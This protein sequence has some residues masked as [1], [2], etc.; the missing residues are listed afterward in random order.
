MGYASAVSIKV[1]PA[2]KAAWIVVIERRRSGRPTPLIC[3][4]VVGQ[5]AYARGSSW[6]FDPLILCLQHNY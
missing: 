6:A 2:S 5:V 1:I 3:A 4:P